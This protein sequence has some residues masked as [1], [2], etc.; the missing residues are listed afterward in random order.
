[1]TAHVCLFT[2]SLAPS[3]VGQH[4]LTLAEELQGRYRLSF[5]CP[6]GSGG[7]PLLER[8]SELGLEVLPLEVRGDAS[9]DAE[10]RAF[11]RDRQV[12]VFHVHAGITW[13]GHAGV[14]SAAGHVPGLVRTEHLAELPAIFPT[15]ELPDLIYSPYHLP[16][17]RPDVEELQAMVERDRAAYLDVARLVDRVV[18]VSAC[19]GNTYVEA[20]L[21]PQKLRVV[22][23]GIRPTP[24]SC[25]REAVRERLGVPLDRP[26]VLSVGRMIDVKGHLFTLGA[27]PEVVRHLPDALFLWVGGGPLEGQLRERVSEEGLQESVW[28][29]G[30]RDDVP[31]LIC[32][33]DL[34][35]LASM[36]EGLPLVVLEA[37]AAGRPVVGTR[38]CGTSEVVEDRVTGR[39]VESGRLDGTGDTSALAAAILEPLVDRDLGARWG[40]AGRERFEREFTS[41]RMARDTAAVYDELLG[42]DG[43][44][45]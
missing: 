6:P 25:R 17:R 34:F 20:G 3:G 29:A 13:E 33:T 12:D 35:L 16:D 26:V 15:E 5:V 44:A 8:A 4:I 22:R 31:D 14:R 42:P 24:A 18:T 41:A 11:L 28:F 30:H 21:E 45:G 10:L 9:A 43:A 32:A 7:T 39:L 38:V 37:M 23:N 2:D 19:V 40:S 1:V 36:V 27:V